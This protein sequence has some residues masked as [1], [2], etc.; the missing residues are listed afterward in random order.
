M[1]EQKE[2]KEA[3]FN[4]GVSVDV[5]TSFLVVS[6]QKKDG[7]FV[8]KVHRN[9]LFPMEI[10]DESADLLERSNYFFIKADNHYYII[11]DDALSIVNAI[12]KGNVIRPM[13]NGI[14]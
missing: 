1:T 8:N 7:T 14:L 5:G 12:G 3:E 4:P 13:A 2:V 9:C 10:T 6:R 11:G